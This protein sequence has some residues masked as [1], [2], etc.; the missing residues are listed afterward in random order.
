MEALHSLL[1]QVMRMQWSDYLDILVVTFIIYRLLP[2]I[3]TPSTMRVARAVIVV[4]VIAAMTDVMHL[5]TLSFL[6][7][8][9][10]SIGLLALVV[11]FQ[12]ELRR[13]LDHLGSVRLGALFGGVKPVA[14]MDM[15]IS[16]TVA[17]CDCMS[18]EKV[19]A[20]I[21]FTRE[22]SLDDYVKTGTT[23]DGRVSEQLIRNI[24]FPKASLH[25]GAMIIREGKIKAAGCVLPLS[26]SDRLAADL[27]TRHRAGVGM[28]ENSDAVVVIVS[29]ETGTISVA[30]GGMLKRHLA[31]KTLEKLLHNA[32]CPE[33]NQQE[34]RNIGQILRQ[35]L[36]RPGKE[37][38]DHEA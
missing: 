10:L 15:V 20:L 7:N 14:E 27:G 38:Q 31:P 4:V 35:K 36:A 21:V 34:N 3:R 6:I 32:L 24:F 25:D 19:G 22:A 2:L 8:Q 16:Q 26:T 28:S 13:M 17:A 23:I 1:Q 37:D 29:E 9:F 18:R 12:P 30:M 5:Y 33:E 11:L